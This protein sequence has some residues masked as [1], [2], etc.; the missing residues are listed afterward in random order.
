MMTMSGH[1]SVM[2][3]R[4]LFDEIS[5]YHNCQGVVAEEHVLELASS[6]QNYVDEGMIV[7]M[8]ICHSRKL[9]VNES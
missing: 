7:N 1:D 8:S 3:H 9:K 5:N 6:M 2:D 4:D